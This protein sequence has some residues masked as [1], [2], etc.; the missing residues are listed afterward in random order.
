Q[1][2]QVPHGPQVPQLVRIDDRAHALDLAVGD[3]EDHHAD[4]PV[5]AVEEQC[6]SAWRA[7]SSSALATSGSGNH[8]PTYVSRRTRAERR[9]SSESRETTVDRYAR[10]D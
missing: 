4:Q 8:S 5:V 3:V 6:T 9:W 1:P 7:G 10:G 2:A